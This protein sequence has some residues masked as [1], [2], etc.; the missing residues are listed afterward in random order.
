MNEFCAELSRTLSL[1][2][3]NYQFWT[4]GVYL[5]AQYGDGHIVRGEEDLGWGRYWGGEDPH[6]VLPVGAFSP[7]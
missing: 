5:L 4:L 1:K 3:N 6:G 2:K 7:T